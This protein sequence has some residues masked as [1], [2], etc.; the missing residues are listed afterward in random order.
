MQRVD[1]MEDETKRE[2]KDIKR[3]KDKD[4]EE[5]LIDVEVLLTTPE[6]CQCGG[7]FEY[8]GLGDYECKICHGKFQNEYGVVRDFV[9][10]Y[11]TNYNI[12]EIAERTGVPKRLIDM[13]IK[14]QRFKTVKKQRKCRVCRSPIEKGH[15][16]NKCALRQIKEEIESD[17]KR[18]IVGSLAKRESMKGE[19]YFI[20]R[21]KIR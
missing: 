12:I 16:C 6:V 7:E 5:V 18:N 1:F 10:E 17:N 4:I 14:D 3:T 11:G 2:M 20:N 15:Y 19:M 8:K 21:D 13:F 9:D